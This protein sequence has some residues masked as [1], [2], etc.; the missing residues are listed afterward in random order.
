MNRIRKYRL[1]VALAIAMLLLVAASSC[2]GT[3]QATS[4]PGVTIVDD[5]AYA[6]DLDQVRALDAETGESLWGYPADVKEARRGFFYVTPAVNET[7]V[8]VASTAPG[9][10]FFSQPQNIVW[11]LDRDG[12]EFWSYRGAE[13][14]Y[15]EGGAI[16]GGMFVIGNSDGNV[17]ALDVENGQLR[18]KF[19]TGHR[20]WAKP[21]IV[22]DVVYIGSM[23]RHLYALSLSNGAELWSFEAGGAFAGTPALLNGTLFIGAFNAKF[24]AIDAERGTEV[25][26]EPFTGENWFWGSPVIDGDIVYAADVNGNV[27]ALD[28]NTRKAIWSTSLL[29]DDCRPAPVRAGVALSEDGELLFVGSETGTLYALDTTDQGRRVWAEPSEGEIFS[30]PIVSGATVFQPLIRGP[31]RIVALLVETGRDLW[32]HPPQVEE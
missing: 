21:L 31:K 30:E 20:V 2:S 7:H 11:A 8:I 12:R 3:A 25:W 22:A 19:E 23:D 1:P 28:T 4:W 10:G 13:G 17:Y 27:Y 29:D 24:Y 16:G 15:V 18:W 5:I 9:G 32:D 14:Q 6:A 26:D